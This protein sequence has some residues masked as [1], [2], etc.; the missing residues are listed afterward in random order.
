MMIEGGKESEMIEEIIADTGMILEREKTDTE[1]AEE[2]M[3][4]PKATTRRLKLIP[5][6]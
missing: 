4:D 1:T 2:G 6:Y 5:K 3:T